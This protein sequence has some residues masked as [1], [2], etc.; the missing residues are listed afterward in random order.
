MKDSERT[1]LVNEL[2][3]LRA[4]AEDL[5]SRLGLCKEERC[6]QE[7]GFFS[8]NHEFFRSLISAIPDLVWIKDLRGVYLACN[9]AFESFFGAKESEIV[10]KTDYDF[11]DRKLADFFREHDLK[12]LEA[13]EPSI[14]EEWLTIADTGKRLLVETVK[15]PVRDNEG[16]LVGILG[17]A[18]DITNRKLTEEDLKKQV[19]MLTS[20][21]GEHDKIRFADLFDIED[22]QRLQDEFADATGVASIITDTDGNAVTTPRNFCRLCTIVR[23]SGKGGANCRKSDVILGNSGNDGPAI[24]ICKSAGLWDAC[25]MISVGGN[26]VANWLIG[27]VRDESQTE[28][29]MRAYAREIGVDE[30]EFA[31]EFQNVPSMTLLKFKQVSI[32]LHTLA[33]Q[34]S[35]IAY[36]NIKQARFIHALTRTKAELATTRNYLSSIIDSMPSLLIGIDQDFQVT[37]WNLVAQK[38]TGISEDDAVGQPLGT[39]L[40]RMASRMDSV[41]AAL[42]SRTPRSVFLETGAAE[43]GT[44]YENV[45]VYPLVAE[46]VEGAVLR[47]DDITE[48]VYMEKMMIQSEKM[49]SVGGLAAGM[50]HEINN[51]LAAIL[52]AATNI[53]NRIFNDLGM[54]EQVADECGVSLQAVRN[55]LSRREVPRMLDAIH[56]SGMRA[57][58]IVRNMLSF[59]R[60]SEAAFQLHD[61]VEII[62]KTLDL[63]ANDYD[64]KKHYDF[65]AIDIIREYDESLPLVY[66]EKN[67]LLQVFLNLFKNGA[68]AMVEKEYV[69]GRP[70]FIC[71]VKRAGATISVQIED[72]GP[73]LD[74]EGLKRVFD[75]FYTTKQ[76]G[77]GTGLGLSVSYFIITDHHGGVFEVDS[78][79]GEWTRFTIRLP[80][81][82]EDS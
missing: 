81:Q 34:L 63:A 35:D 48:R 4:R 13:N 33:A 55:Y 66:C 8:E 58:D 24:H 20:P 38:N 16:F 5:E 27:Q 54:N 45:T 30:D 72:N 44:R 56:E 6:K 19:S 67:E 50:A 3:I 37:Q 39:V 14:N 28:E 31:R 2:Q 59:S 29:S 71:R 49:L 60:K 9:E 32:V 70:R 68:E 18:R 61:I 79:L 11:V 74:K 64:L 10:G 15:T 7:C 77:Q 36:Q 73:G 1:K 40:P 12:A 26:H 78:E 62:E 46:G 23:S 75:P 69:D 51:P 80:L 21:A 17:V 41:E 22:I 25:A 65:R 42:L 47:I 76:A 43:G 53:N 52:G 82:K 57:A